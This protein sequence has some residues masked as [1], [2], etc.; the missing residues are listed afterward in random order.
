L[1]LKGE[2]NYNWQTG[3]VRRLNAAGKNME[4]LFSGS[5]K[6]LIA[7]LLTVDPAKRLTAT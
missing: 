4:D 2:Y 1:I 5:A 7:S 6:D 3:S